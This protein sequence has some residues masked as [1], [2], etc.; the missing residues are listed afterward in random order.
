LS[1][2]VHDATD[3][4]RTALGRLAIVDRNLARIREHADGMGGDL[5]VL[6]KSELDLENERSRLQVESEG[7]RHE[8]ER[9]GL[10][11]AEIDAVER[12]GHPPPYQALWKHALERQGLWPPAAEAI[13][14]ALP[15]AQRDLPWVVAS[16]GELAAAGQA[17]QDLAGALDEEPRLPARFAEAASLL[18]DGTPLATVR[19]LAHGGALEAQMVLRAPPTDAAWDVLGVT[20]RPG[21]RVEAGEALI[22]L[23]DP[24]RMWLRLEPIGAETAHVV[25]VFEERI[26]FAA[27]PLVAGAGPRIEDLRIARLASNGDAG[28]EGTRAYCD[29]DNTAVCPPPG[30]AACSW[31][32]RAGTRYLAEVPVER[33]EGRFVLPAD[34]LAERGPDR[35]VF[36][37]DGGT[38]RP[39]VVHVEYADRDVVVVADDGSLFEGDPVATSGA[40]AL[41]LAL[42]VGSGPASEA[43]HGHA[44]D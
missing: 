25:R 5:P 34:A 12:G 24:R 31:R 32:L 39:Q 11:E 30:G 17:D 44:H 35:V 6:R 26:P 43:G 23:H 7:A 19:L 9:H 22:T 41:G 38:F 29:V 27:R 13:R 36:V 8:L 40:F 3:R 4:L 16:I 28:N 20:A 1:E 18:L 37:R 33:F 10:S 14:R 21:R 15:E 42:Q 2:E